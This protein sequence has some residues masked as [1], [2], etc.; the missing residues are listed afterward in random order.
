M[1][2]ETKNQTTKQIIAQ[3]FN[4]IIKV[5]TL[6]KMHIIKRVRKDSVIIWLGMHMG[7]SNRVL[8]MNIKKLLLNQHL[9]QDHKKYQS[10][11]SKKWKKRKGRKSR[12]TNKWNKII[13]F[14]RTS[15]KKE[16]PDFSQLINWKL[17]P[18]LQKIIGWVIK[19]N[20]KKIEGFRIINFNLCFVNLI[21]SK[22]IEI[23]KKQ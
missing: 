16:T 22:T 5:K 8:M 21:R 6:R 12:K 7:S 2:W 20:G 3:A 19:R 15:S 9:I 14:L 18:H 13:I 11:K 4:I 10:R 17:K 1:E 23:I